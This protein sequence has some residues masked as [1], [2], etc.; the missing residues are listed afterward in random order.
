MHTTESGELDCDA[1]EVPARTGAERELTVEEERRSGS[2]SLAGSTEQ[3]GPAT[4]GGQPRR[5]MGVG[6]LAGWTKFVAGD[7]NGHGHRTG[8]W[9]G[10]ALDPV[11]GHLRIR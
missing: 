4:T 2:L 7:E 9:T 8:K 11:A 3:E 5:W 10:R 1:L 6:G